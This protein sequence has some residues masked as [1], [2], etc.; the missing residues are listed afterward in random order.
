MS[1]HLHLIL[2]AK[3]DNLSDVI[4]DFKKFTSKQIINTIT[5]NTKESRRN[6]MLNIF[7]FVGRKKSNNSKYQFW[8]QHNHPIEL[9]SN[10]IM[11]Q[12]LNYIHQNP[13]RN[14]LVEN[15]EDYLESVFKV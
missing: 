6:W 8:Q 15:A 3:N 10:S 14:F 11:E 1:N 2:Q 7:E 5:E 13:V 12:K 9:I 4:R